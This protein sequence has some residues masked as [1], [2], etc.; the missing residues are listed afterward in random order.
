MPSSLPSRDIQ[1]FFEESAPYH[2]RLFY[3]ACNYM[4]D[5]DEAEDVVQDVLIKASQK[6]ET[7]ED[8]SSIYTWLV[9]ILINHCHD[10]KRLHKRRRTHS[11]E[12][13]AP[14]GKELQIEDPSSDHVRN[15]ELS[16]TSAR[17]MNIVQ[18]L[19]DPYKEL[20]LLR[21]FEEMQYKDIAKA[22]D[23]SEGTVKSRLN[24]ARKLLR[25]RLSKEGI[26]EAFLVS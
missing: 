17:L 4:R 18:T 16:E 6:Y 22:L 14:D 3:L 24:Q 20:V 12:E 8:R 26:G 5:P 21:Y 25:D 2:E 19:A 13:I 9:R 15:F 7:F 1:E 10:I 23:L 11:I